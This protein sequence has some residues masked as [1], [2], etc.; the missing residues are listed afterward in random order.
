MLAGYE[1]VVKECLRRGIEAGVERDDLKELRGDLRVLAE[2]FSQG[3]RWEE[4][5]EAMGEDEDW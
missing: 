2:G 3:E 4:V 1:E 5:E